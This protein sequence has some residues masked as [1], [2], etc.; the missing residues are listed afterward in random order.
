MIHPSARSLPALLVAALTTLGACQVAPTW[1]DAFP[2]EI[3]DDRGKQVVIEQRPESV[4][5]ISTFG[6]DLVTALGGQM[7]GL[8]TLNGKQSAFLGDAATGAVNLGE[9]HQ[10]NLEV[11]TQLAPDLIVG[12]RTYTQPFEKK[13]E[14]AGTFIAL[15][16]TTLEDSLSAV[17]R[18]SRALG[19]E[20]RGQALNARF[21]SDLETF[22]TKA[23]G[24]VTA[25]FLWDWADVPYAFYDHYLTTRIMGH[26]GATNVQGHRPTPELEM[27]DSAAIGL[28]TLLRLDPDVILVFKGQDGPVAANPVWSRLK[29][30]RNGR[31]WRVNDQYIMS[32]G[33]LAR[34]M[35]LREMA[36]LLYP[37]TFPEPEDIP[38]AARAVPLNV[39]N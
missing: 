2:V 5:A 12:L 33:P 39:A 24:G 31:A 30:V 4:A 14:E 17:E 25:V 6:A 20:D 29:A 27:P 21:L 8:S 35:V 32:H 18:L 38:S 15:D 11:L 28:E 37:E 22:G 3:L 10:A 1:A 23:P 36:H 16:L 13:I 26:L 19:E 9:I 34:E 7:A